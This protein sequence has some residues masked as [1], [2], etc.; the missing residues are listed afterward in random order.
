MLVANSSPTDKS[1]VCVVIVTQIKVR[2][3]SG[4]SCIIKMKIVL[5]FQHLLNKNIIIFMTF[6]EIFVFLR[7][8]F[9]NRFYTS[10]HE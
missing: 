6:H 10:F 5:K 8:L 2:R 4:R 3:M 7:T 1:L 9:F